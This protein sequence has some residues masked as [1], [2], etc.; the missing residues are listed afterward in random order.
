M[1]EI[2]RIMVLYYACEVSAE[3][4]FPS[5]QEWARCMGYYHAIKRHFADGEVGPDANARGYLAFREWE[6]AHPDTVAELR[7]RSSH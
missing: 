6:A 5:P 7:A 2:L 3:T 4:Q 1:A